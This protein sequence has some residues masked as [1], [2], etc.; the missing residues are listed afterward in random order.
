MDVASNLHALQ[1]DLASGPASMHMLPDAH[2][3]ARY[4]Q[5]KITPN[6]TRFA[7]GM[8]EEVSKAVDEYFPKSEDGW[9]EMDP[10]DMLLKISARMSSRVNLGKEWSRN[11]QWTGAARGYTQNGKYAHCIRTFLAPAD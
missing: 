8:Q 9:V 10:S 4:V 5:R 11:P 3:H 1:F 7:T 2:L 6:L